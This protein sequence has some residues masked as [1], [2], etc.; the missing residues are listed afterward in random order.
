MHPHKAPRPEGMSPLFVQKYW[1]IV[2]DNVTHFVLN[3][4]NNSHD[5]SHMN[6]TH[7]ILIPKKKHY[8]TPAD[9][10]PISLCNVVYKIVSK[11]IANRLK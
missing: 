2:G 1:H 10:R 9:F 4:L 7:L 3:V 8:E 6:E 5:I 11:V